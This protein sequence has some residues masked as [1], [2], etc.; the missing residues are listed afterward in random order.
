MIENAS[1]RAELQKR[2]VSPKPLLKQFS[3]WIPESAGYLLFKLI[4]FNPSKRISATVES[5]ERGEK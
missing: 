4:Q 2:V 1:I 5:E 3:R